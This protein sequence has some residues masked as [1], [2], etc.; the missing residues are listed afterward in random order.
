MKNQNLAHTTL[1]GLVDVTK[2]SYYREVIAGLE[3]EIAEL[4]EAQQRAEAQYVASQESLSQA[5]VDFNREKRRADELE[6]ALE[7]VKADYEKKVIEFGKLSSRNNELQGAYND[8][9]RRLQ[10]FDRQRGKGGRFTR[11]NNEE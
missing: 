6:K 3:E 10:K 1:F 11:K 7:Q 4:Y 2:R 5:A 8:A 9:K